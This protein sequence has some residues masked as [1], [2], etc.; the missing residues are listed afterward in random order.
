MTNYR[1]KQNGAGVIGKIIAGVLAL[2]VVAGG[3]CACGFAARDDDGKWFSNGNISTWHWSDKLPDSGNQDKPAGV[4]TDGMTV[5]TVSSNKM[6]LRAMPMT[7]N[8]PKATDSSYYLTATVEPA[9]AWEQEIEWLVSFKDPA[10]AWASGKSASSYVSV[11]PSSDT[12]N[13]TVTCLGAF[14]EQVIITARS[15]DNPEATATCTCDYVKRATNV[16]VIFSEVN[17]TGMTYTCEYEYSAYTVDSEIQLSSATIQGEYSFSNDI[18]D[19]LDGNKIFGNSEYANL[20]QA[21]FDTVNAVSAAGLRQLT[22]TSN[23]V[24][25]TNGFYDVVNLSGNYTDLDGEGSYDLTDSQMS[26]LRAAYIQAVK[27][28]ISS[29][30]GV[31]AT[32]NLNFEIVRDGTRFGTQGVSINMNFTY[33]NVK[34]PVYNFVLDKDHIDF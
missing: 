10:A 6:R 33:D 29:Y 31:Q 21:G 34:V 8:A 11:A 28:S 20:Q 18:R 19:R 32:L 15:K 4:A 7:A 17:T 9:D 1:K 13:A 16:K 2:V 26:K 14:G 12:H 30:T 25:L 22:T 27:E 24:K 3:V 23:T 5:N